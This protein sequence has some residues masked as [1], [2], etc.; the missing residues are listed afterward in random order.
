[1]P[2]KIML[3]S[4]LVITALAVFGHITQA[5][6]A[7]DGRIEGTEQIE[8]TEESEQIE[9]EEILPFPVL[10]ITSELDPFIQYRRF[11]H[12]GTLSLS[13]SNVEYGDFTDVAVGLRGR[14]N[15]TWWDG[16]DKRP[17]RIRFEEAQSLLGSEYEAADWILLADHFDRSLMRNYAALTF[18][19][20]LGS[21]PFTPRPHHVQL[22]VNGEYMGVYLLTDE[23]DVQPGR[24][25]IA[26]DPDPALSGFMIELDARAP[27]S[28]EYD[29][30]FVTVHGMHYD[31]RYP[32]RNSRRTQEHVDYVRGYLETVS[33]TI[34]SGNFGQAMTLI[35]L[36]TF[37]DF[38][39]V[40]ELFKNADV[41]SLSVFMYITG[42][43]AERRLYM[44]PV[45]DFDIAAGNKRDMP[46]GSNPYYIFAAVV[47]YWY[48]HLMQMPEFREAVTE[49]WN[50]IRDEQVVQMIADIRARAERYHSE[51]IRNFGR[52]RVMGV[53]GFG[54]P[55]EILAI[56]T[57]SGQVE[58]L[59]QWFEARSVWLDDYF[60]DRLPGHDPMWRLVEYYALER[61]RQVRIY[62]ED[63]AYRMAGVHLISLHNRTMVSILE[64]AYLFDLSVH[65]DVMTRTYTL[66]RGEMEI[67]YRRGTDF[68]TVDGER[69]D[70]PA[71][72]ILEILDLVYI[73]LYRMVEFLGYQAA[74]AVGE[75]T[76]V[77]RPA[78][79]YEIYGI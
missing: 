17:L 73:P 21:M 44:G 75:G 78:E 66:S 11:W 55:A 40:Q 69:F 10:H 36:D 42:E 9:E 13:G 60:N 33:Q 52:H 67:S 64:A 77:I 34:R 79:D 48:R 57:F 16:E 30:T 68:L 15:S 29:D 19:E 51:F 70:L 61:P 5:M 6:M 76:L 2:K 54:S 12:D 63:D 14:G 53:R 26:W 50:E 59:A 43:G 20:S 62:D 46:L 65:F 58:H 35:D 3:W 1:M 8:Q 49:R 39:L 18:A 28:G 41:H 47:N 45:W 71:P 74:W 37:V 32:S 56:L 25:E 27:Q 4:L 31:I 22:Y 38:Y 72:G 7:Q 23:R 24:L